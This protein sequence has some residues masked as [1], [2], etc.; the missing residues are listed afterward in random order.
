MERL[1]KNTIDIFLIGRGVDETRG[2]DYLFPYFFWYQHN[3]ILVGHHQVARRNYSNFEKSESNS[4]TILR[5]A[6]IS[7]LLVL[8]HVS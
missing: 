3:A 8:N 4:A 1:V 6:S 2:F 7:T 5:E